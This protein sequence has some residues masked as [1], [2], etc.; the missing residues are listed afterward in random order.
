MTNYKKEI[1]EIL[2]KKDEDGFYIPLAES[3]KKILALISKVRD[4]AYKEGALNQALLDADTIKKARED[5]IE[6]LKD[7]PRIEITHK[8][9]SKTRA[10]LEH[11]LETHGLLRGEGE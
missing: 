4:E 10:I 11:S 9:G 1:K 3:E 2:Y 5:L 7:I 6:R 8:D